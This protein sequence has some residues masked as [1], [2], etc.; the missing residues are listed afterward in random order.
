MVEMGGGIPTWDLSADLMPR[1]R[2]NLLVTEFWI[3]SGSGP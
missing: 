1:Y 2:L 3:A